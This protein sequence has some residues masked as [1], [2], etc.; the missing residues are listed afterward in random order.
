MLWG[1][2]TAGWLTIFGTVLYL[3][4]LEGLLSADN[5]LVLAV[6]VRHLPK[7]QQKRALRYGIWGAFIFR[8]IAVIFASILLRFW[9]LKV[10]GGLYLLF[11]AVRHFL[12][13]EHRQ[14]KGAVRRGGG[15][16]ATV[17]NVELA[18]IAFSIDSIL[19]AVALAE[20][21]PKEIANQM[22]QPIPFLA[23]FPLKLMIVYIGG[24]LGIVAMRLVAGVFLVVLERFPGL[25][26]GAYWLVA[27]IGVKLVESGL[28]QRFHAWIPEMPEEVFW[29]GMILI[30]ILSLVYQPRK[31]T[32]PPHQDIARPTAPHGH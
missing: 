2:D 28:A 21:L 26:N 7:P 4:L 22:I 27:W 9:W 20:A 10:A 18:D 25:V 30:V 12:T 24:V 11:L 5:A 19:A 29:G 31:P 13:G 3:V 32:K 8:L 23:S 14:T 6:M 16:W 1:I 17:I 15:F